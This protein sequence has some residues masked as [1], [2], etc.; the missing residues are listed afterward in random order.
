MSCSYTSEA[1]IILYIKCDL[2]IKS[3]LKNVYIML[4]SQDE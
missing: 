3:S 2:K 4:P 1:N